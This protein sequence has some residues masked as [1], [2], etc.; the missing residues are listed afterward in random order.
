MNEEITVRT[1]MVPVIGWVA[2]AFFTFC[3]VMSVVNG[4]AILSLS[5]IPFILIGVPVVFMARS[6]TANDSAITA[7]TIKGTYAIDWDDIAEV[8]I[9]KS[10]IL[11]KGRDGRQLIIPTPSMWGFSTKRAMQT[12]LQAEIDRRGL[13]FKRSVACD[14]RFFKGT[15]IA[16][17]SPSPLRDTRGGSR[18]GET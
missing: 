12:F 14:Y 16:K 4:L 17:Q 3:A 11:F 10:N 6:F 9:G 1:F 5:F 7:R 15:R 2:I 18:E 8:F 13:S